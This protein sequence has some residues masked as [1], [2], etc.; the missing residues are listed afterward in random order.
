MYGK[1]NVKR[2]VSQNKSRTQRIE[3]LKQ[4][5]R[6]GMDM[7]TPSASG[8]EES[9][10]G[11]GL[12]RGGDSTGSG[13]QGPDEVEKLL[14]WTNALDFNEPLLTLTPPL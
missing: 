9:G 2:S 14:E 6:K 13:A 12:L 11:D 8:R 3:Q 4:M 7:N 10:G 5:Y 1:S